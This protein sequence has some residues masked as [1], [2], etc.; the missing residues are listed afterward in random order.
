MLE[1]QHLHTVTFESH[2][3]AFMTSAYSNV[4]HAYAFASRRAHSHS[5]MLSEATADQGRSL[6]AL[7]DPYI[8]NIN[9]ITP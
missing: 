6:C 1:Q 3:N 4:A 9:K 5:L 8:I 7:A 2:V